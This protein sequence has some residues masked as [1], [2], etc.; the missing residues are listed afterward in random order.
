MLEKIFECMGYE[1]M[2][3]IVQNT[4]RLQAEWKNAT[5]KIICTFLINKNRY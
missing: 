3:L 2:K 4:T 1:E 5:K